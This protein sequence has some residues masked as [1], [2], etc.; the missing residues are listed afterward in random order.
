MEVAAAQAEEGQQKE[1]IQKVADMLKNEAQGR[2]HIRVVGHG[3]P[4]RPALPLRSRRRRAAGDR[5]GCRR[6][7]RAADAAAAASE[8]PLQLAS[9][10]LLARRSRRR[11]RYLFIR[12]SAPAATARM[13]QQ[14][15]QA[16]ESRCSA[17][18]V[19]PVRISQMPSSSM[20]VFE[21]VSWSSSFSREDRCTWHAN[22]S[23]YLSESRKYRAT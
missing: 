19:S 2:D 23:A 22:G 15:R 16:L 21:A 11:F 8:Q 13:C 5:Q 1:V 20:P 18:A 7:P 3:H 14:R 6:G 12:I 9:V 17:A 4:E 10:D